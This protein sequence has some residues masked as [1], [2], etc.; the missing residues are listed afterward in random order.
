MRQKC[1]LQKYA[2][3]RISVTYLCPCLL[4]KLK[5]MVKDKVD[6]SVYAVTHAMVMF[7]N[8]KD[9]RLLGQKQSGA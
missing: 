4:D 1:R 5:C 2:L 8:L 6:T 7:V 9:L 3:C